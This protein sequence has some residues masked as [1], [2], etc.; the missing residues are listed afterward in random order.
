MLHPTEEIQPKP[1]LA[2]LT[3]NVEVVTSLLSKCTLLRAFKFEVERQFNGEK[4]AQMV[5]Q[6][7]RAASLRTDD[8]RI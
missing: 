8:R 7:L 6:V 2:W 5:L 3:V 1:Q 4:S